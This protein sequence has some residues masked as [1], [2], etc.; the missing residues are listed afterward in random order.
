MVV[1]VVVVAA[2]VV[3]VTNVAVDELPEVRRQIRFLPTSVQRADWEPTRRTS[4]TVLHVVP[5]INGAD[6]V[7]LSTARSIT[8]TAS[9]GASGTAMGSRPVSAAAPADTA[10]QT[11]HM[12]GKS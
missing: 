9:G 5:K 1:V 11:T 7:L 12:L 8:A 6:E 4:P 3:V 2:I 10:W